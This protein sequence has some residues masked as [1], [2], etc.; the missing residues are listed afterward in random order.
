MDLNWNTSVT[1]SSEKRKTIS[2]KKPAIK[3]TNGLISEINSE[4]GSAKFLVSIC[5]QPSEGASYLDVLNLYDSEYCAFPIT[6]DIAINPFRIRKETSDGSRYLLKSV[7]AVTFHLLARKNGDDGLHLR[8]F[9]YH[10]ASLSE[11]NQELS[12]DINDGIK[13]LDTL[14]LLF[15]F[16]AM[17]TA[18]SSWTIH[19]RQAYRI[20]DCSGGIKAIE[21]SARLRAQV[22]MIIWW[23][24]TLALVCQRPPVFPSSYTLA[25]ISQNDVWTFFD[26]VGCP[27]Q[28]VVYMAALA[29]LDRSGSTWTEELGEIYSDIEGYQNECD[30]NNLVPGDESMD[31]FRSRYHCGEA[32]KKC[33]MLYILQLDMRQ[34]TSEIQRL[35]NHVL[36]HV[37]QIDR[38]KNAQIQKQVLFPVF[39]AGAEARNAKCRDMIREYCQYWSAEVGFWMFS[40]ILELLEKVWEQIDNNTPFFCCWFETLLSSSDPHNETEYLVS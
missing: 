38:L 15:T 7:L 39:I 3:N 1:V 30:Y 26:L 16:K 17:Q 6:L 14:I 24:L 18:R 12:V 31:Y 32:W 19:L 22:A 25:V 27:N 8:A 36:N 29:F 34:P 5:Q 4:S 20:L 11:F 2:K 9:D 23:D 40:T 10:Y 35:S 28:L 33:L 21:N 13:Y 37:F